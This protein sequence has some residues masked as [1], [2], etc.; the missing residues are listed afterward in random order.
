MTLTV[1]ELIPNEPEDMPRAEGRPSTYTT[2]PSEVECH[3]SKASQQVRRSIA[4]DATKPLESK[5]SPLTT[6]PSVA[7]QLAVS[8]SDSFNDEPVMS[9]EDRHAQ[10]EKEAELQSAERQLADAAQEINRL[11]AAL[12]DERARGSEVNQ[13]LTRLQR[14]V[15]TATACT[16]H[17]GA[18]S[19]L[20]C[21]LEANWVVEVS[22]RDERLRECLTALEEE[23][24]QRHLAETHRD[25]LALLYGQKDR[26]V[27]RCLTRLESAEV[28][29]ASAYETIKSL[30]HEKLKITEQM[31]IKVKRDCE[32]ER[33]LKL[34]AEYTASLKCY[35]DELKKLN[36]EDRK[37]SAALISEKAIVEIRT[38]QIDRLRKEFTLLQQDYD[39]L[40][41]LI[42]RERKVTLSERIGLA[43]H[44]KWKKF[45]SFFTRKP[46]QKPIVSPL[47]PE[48]DLYSDCASVGSISAEHMALV[49]NDA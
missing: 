4:V 7:C 37:M 17:T 15:A 48:D 19:L 11:R 44:N 33:V 42:T 47:V 45:K 46:Y 38:R 3:A 39:Y 1:L 23:R 14:D 36:K 29:A 31:N 5:G 13:A 25:S 21:A 32:D 27:E 9:E 20:A 30:T 16:E 41:R 12:Q 26:E 49:M 18:S 6:V 2:S 8:L 34:H 22:N 10:D 43:I 24:R 28:N 40:K 35:Q